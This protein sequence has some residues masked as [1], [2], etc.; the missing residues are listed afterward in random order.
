MLTLVKAQVWK[1]KSIEDS[2]LVTIDDEVTVLVGKNE[3]GKT[4]FLEA[5]LKSHPLEKEAYDYVADYPRKDLVRYRPKHEASDYQKVVELTFKIKKELAEKINNEVFEGASIFKADMLF[6]RSS[7]YGNGSNVGLEFNESDALEALRKPLSGLEHVDDVFDKATSMAGILDK[8]AGLD[9]AADSMLQIFADKWSKKKGKV[10]GWRVLHWH[11]WSTYL[12]PAL[13][14][15]LYFDDYKLLQGKIN[16]PTLKARQQAEQL[17]NADETALG[18]LELA[19]ATLDD[20]M[21]DEG[22]ESSKAKLV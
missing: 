10:A 7:H 1:Y 21:S 8:I 3:S 6:T 13:P 19:G 14:K 9:L 17:E 5:L 16:L 4:A 15:F 12:S 11:I 20:L 2:T 18:L 22:Y